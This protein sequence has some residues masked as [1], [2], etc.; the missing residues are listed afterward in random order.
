MFHWIV[1]SC[2]TAP[3]HLR[4]Q[5][6]RHLRQQETRL[7]IVRSL[8]LFLTIA[9]FLSLIHL[10]YFYPSSFTGLTLWGVWGVCVCVI[11]SIDGAWSWAAYSISLKACRHNA[12]KLVVRKHPSVWLR[13]CTWLQVTVQLQAYFGAALTKVANNWNN[14]IELVFRLDGAASQ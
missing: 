2:I 8:S 5:L 6:S 13:K 3:K 12:V 10:N 9:T 4:C 14:N 1:S 11:P 7:N